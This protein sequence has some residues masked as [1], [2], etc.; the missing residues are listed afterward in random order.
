MGTVEDQS[1]TGEEERDTDGRKLLREVRN[2]SL[3]ATERQ[4]RGFSS[5]ICSK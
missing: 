4:D 5:F 3:T 1:G 2:L